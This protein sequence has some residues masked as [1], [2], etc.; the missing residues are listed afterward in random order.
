MIF[1][2]PIPW[3]APDPLLPPLSLLHRPS[4]ESSPRPRVEKSVNR[5]APLGPLRKIPPFV[6]A[7]VILPSF[8]SPLLASDAASIPLEKISW[9]LLITGLLGGLGLFLYGIEKMSEG[10]KLAAGN[11][12]RAVLKALTANR[13]IAL[14]FG[15]VVTMVVQS[16]SATTVML[17]GFV[18]AGLMGFSRSVGVILGADIGTT[19]TAQLIAFKLTNYALLLV[20]VGAGLRMFARNDNLRNA[21]EAVLGFG[22]LFLGMKLM[23]ETMH[24]LRSY[25]EL[26]DFMRGLENPLAG[27]LAGTLLT[28]LLQSSS[29]FI[30]IVIVLAQQGLISLQAGIPMILGANV[31]TCI[32]ALVA[33]TGLSRDAKRVAV[34]HVLF[35]VSGVLLFVF[36]IPTFAA[37]V[38]AMAVRFDSDMARQIANAHSIFNVGLAVVFL[39]FATI[40]AKLVVAMLPDIRADRDIKPALLHLDEKHMVAPV[41]ALSLARAEISRMA[42]LLWRMMRAVIVPFMS[43]PRL[44]VK[45]ADSKEERRLLLREIPTRDEYFPQLTLMEGL[46]MREEKLDFLEEKISDYLLKIAKQ[47]LSAV[48]TAEVYDMMSI[49]KDLESIGDL[50]HRNMLPLIEK[51]KA[52]NMDFSDDGKEEL[53][54]YHEKVCSHLRLLAEAFGET[55]PQ[56]ACRIMEQEEEYLDLERHYRLKHLQRLQYE[57]KE[58]ITTHEVHMELMDLMKQIITYTTDIARVFATRCTP[59]HLQDG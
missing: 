35:K 36:W 3:I 12:F 58:A 49:V 16:S 28:A 31:G 47:E 29:A 39:P 9:G 53:L 50:I 19:V 33:A 41:V 23:S 54:I 55:S 56:K 24:P 22:M 51:K 52:L 17:V 20:A 25:P 37:W 1:P 10:M 46:D 13:M 2:R 18:E 57:Q 14:V 26:I 34:L 4:G 7:L 59:S 30:G 6:I 11:R 15:A 42:R 27:L 40:F 21:G 43:D 44:I 45:D 5:R 32:T 48:Q 8:S 38:Q